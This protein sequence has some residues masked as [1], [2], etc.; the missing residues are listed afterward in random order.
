MLSKV[1]IHELGGLLTQQLQADMYRRAYAGQSSD[2]PTLVNS[3]TMAGKDKDAKVVDGV[4]RLRSEPRPDFSK[5]PEHHD[6]PKD[7][8]KI[9][10]VADQ[11][12]LYEEIWSGQ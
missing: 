12:S 4:K 5:P 11:E 7:L 9:V 10:E 1:E 3:T 2:D 6:L 8:Q